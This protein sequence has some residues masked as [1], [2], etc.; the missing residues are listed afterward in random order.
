MPRSLAHLV[1]ASALAGAV[2]TIH[3]LTGSAS[4]A[5]K[6]RVVPPPAVDAAASTAKSE[7]AVLAGGCF[8]GVQG[9]YQHVK[10]VTRAVSGYAGGEKKTAEY[11]VVGAGGTGHAESVQIT[12][13]P[14]VVSYGRLLQIFFSVAHDPTQLNRQ[15]P[16]TGTQYRSAIFPTSP[17]QAETA[18]AYI[19]QLDQAHVFDRAIVTRIEPGRAFYPAEDYH[20]DFLEQNPTHPYIRYNDL[21]KI[22]DLKRLFPEAYRSRAVLVGA[23]R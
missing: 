3:G 15:G 4:S 10:G 19:A 11:E 1:A 6:A 20:Q 9:V 2:L 22:E 5:E 18:K 12:F 16:D 13:D 21:P 7:V 17:E 23:G 14:R 8:W